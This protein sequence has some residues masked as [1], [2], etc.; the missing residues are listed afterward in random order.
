MTIQKYV[1]KRNFSRTNEPSGIKHVTKKTSMYRF[2]I[3]KHDASR[4]HYDFRLE[5][6]D[7]ILKSWAIPKGIS[8]DPQIKR[9]A[10]LVED[11]PLDYINFEGVIPENNYGAGTVIVWDTGLYATKKSMNQQFR[12]G[13]ITFILYGN[14]IKGLFSLIK[15]K[16]AKSKDENQWLLIKSKDEL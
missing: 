14:K 7:G 12:D 5:T 4:L 9:L 8:M 2:V 6:E 1:Q 11:H 13:K 10:V 16:N 15:I 3:Q